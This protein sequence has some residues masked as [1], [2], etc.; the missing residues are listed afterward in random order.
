MW[1]FGGEIYVGYKDGRTHYQDAFGRTQPENK[2][3]KKRPATVEPGRNEPCG[4][5]SG[6]KYKKCCLNKP[7]SQRTTWEELSIRE[8]NLI[9]ADG[10]Y[11]ILG[12]ADGKTWYDVR[13]DLSS[14]QVREVHELYGSLW[15]LD[16]DILKLLPKPDGSLRALYTGI[17]DPRTVGRSVTSLVPYFDEVLAE[18]PFINPRSTRK[19]YSPIDSPHQ[20][21]AQT[22]KNVAL[23]LSLIPFIEAGYINLFPNPSVFDRHLLEQM[24]NMAEARSQSRPIVSKDRRLM[25]RLHKD[26]FERNMWL[27]PKEAQKQQI[28]RAL[29]HMTDHE[30][31]ETLEYIASKREADQLSLLQDDAI[32]GD[33]GGQLLVSSMSPNFEMSLYIAQATGSLIVTDSQTRWEEIMHAQNRRDGV[34]NYPWNDLTDFI[35]GKE[36]PLSADERENFA[37]RQSGKL[38][39]VRNS[40]KK[41]Y[42]A[43]TTN[44]SDSNAVDL[45]RDEFERACSATSTKVD[46]TQSSFK[47]T[48]ECVIPE[49]GVIHNNVQRL[50]LSS[51][52]ENH[53]DSVPMAVLI[54]EAT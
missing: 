29:P 48:F 47:A 45:L 27:L 6:H 12:L 1:Q 23:F 4:C 13:R 14:H 21:K 49:G 39:D 30:V 9:L 42:N 25:E 3:L 54:N 43:V 32:R 22:L 44:P 11:K 18:T 31:E 15:P 5:G 50:L 33:E 24:F 2:Y 16:T 35:K 51:G 34:V 38:R 7:R 8:R 19:E 28:K 41:I 10:I 17:I 20:Y 53:T 36:L 52:V 26:D 37:L 40:L 46:E